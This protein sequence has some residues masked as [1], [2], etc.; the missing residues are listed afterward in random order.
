MKKTLFTILMAIVIGFTFGY[1]FLRKFNTDTLME[2]SSIK[3][4]CYAFPSRI[5]FTVVSMI[6]CKVL[7]DLSNFS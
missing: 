4:Q 3:N 2:V 5:G 7:Q 6:S 1:L